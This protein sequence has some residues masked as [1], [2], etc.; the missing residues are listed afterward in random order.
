MPKLVPVKKPVNKNRPLKPK[1]KNSQAM[2]KFKISEQAKEITR[3]QKLLVKSEVK[4]ESE[5]ARLKAKLAE[6]K[7]KKSNVK[8]IVKHGANP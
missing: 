8:F 5:I 1:V 6:E 4:H 7:K 3:L 2:D